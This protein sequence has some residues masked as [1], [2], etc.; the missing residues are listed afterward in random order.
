MMRAGGLS[1]S[2]I[3]RLYCNPIKLQENGLRVIYSAVCTVQLALHFPPAY[4]LGHVCVQ[5][6]CVRIKLQ[7]F[8]YR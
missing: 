3:T 4:M 2:T 8:C 1:A 6:K 5:A 7:L